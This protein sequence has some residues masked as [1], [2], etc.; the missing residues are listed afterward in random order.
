ME[1]DAR[2]ENVANAFAQYA[3]DG[4]SLGIAAFMLPF[5]GTYYAEMRIPLGEFFPTIQKSVYQ[6]NPSWAV[7][8]TNC[9]TANGSCYGFKGN[10][11]MLVVLLSKTGALTRLFS[12]LDDAAA[13]V[14]LKTHG[15]LRVFPVSDYTPTV[16]A[17][18]KAESRQAIKPPK[19]FEIV[20]DN[21]KA[22][23]TCLEA[24]RDP[25]PLTLI[26]SSSSTPIDEATMARPDSLRLVGKSPSWASR[27]GSNLNI[28]PDGAARHDLTFVCRS[29]GLFSS[30]VLPGSL[31]VE[32]TYKR[33]ART[34]GWWIDLSAENPWQFPHKAYRLLELV[35]KVQELAIQSQSPRTLRVEIFLKST[36]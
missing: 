30:S 36:N 8:Q 31:Q 11:P 4:W 5:D 14:L 19:I 28:Q 29:P 25:H 1:D 7:K 20:N 13:Q 35:N 27:T 24:G 10:R 33:T 12:V 22:E 26:V 2:L 23:F 34:Q 9:T 16:R 6:A 21:V 15:K 18:L 3:R 17:E 32:Y